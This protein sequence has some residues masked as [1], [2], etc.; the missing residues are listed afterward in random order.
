MVRWWR[1]QEEVWNGQKKGLIQ[2]DIGVFKVS[3]L[4]LAGRFMSVLLLKMTKYI[5]KQI[6]K[7]TGPL[8][9]LISTDAINNFLQNIGGNIHNSCFENKTRKFLFY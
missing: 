4:V 2:L 5:N 8:C 7:Q 9:P 6:N 1:G 3:A